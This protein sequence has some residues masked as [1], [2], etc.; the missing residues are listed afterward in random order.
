MASKISEWL[1]KKKGIP[2][3]D[4]LEK[5]GTKDLFSTQAIANEFI[6]RLPIDAA[7]LLYKACRIKLGI[8]EGEN[9]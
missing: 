2:E 4:F 7:E 6:S 5:T 3:F 9:P 8:S 1:K